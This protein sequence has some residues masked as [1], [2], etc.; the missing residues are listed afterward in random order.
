MQKFCHQNKWQIKQRK[1]KNLLKS[2]QRKKLIEYNHHSKE[3][4]KCLNEQIRKRDGIEHKPKL[5]MNN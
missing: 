1:Q 5:Y 2:E 4:L 3:E